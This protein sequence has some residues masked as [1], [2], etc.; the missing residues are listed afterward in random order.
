LGTKRKG[1]SQA[2]CSVQP[3]TSCVSSP[4]P[5][6]LKAGPL[7]GR[8]WWCWDRGETLQA[9]TVLLPTSTV[10]VRQSPHQGPHGLEWL[11]LSH[12][13]ARLHNSGKSEKDKGGHQMDLRTVSL[14]LSPFPCTSHWPEFAPMAM[15]SR[16]GCWEP[17]FLFLTACASR[18]L[19]VSFLWEGRRTGIGGHLA[20]LS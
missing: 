6:T 7:E 1:E 13:R 10:T 18:S 19:G 5:Q 12:A 16:Q 15:L 14:K 11:W 3:S 8:L 17:L 4:M 9:P 2:A 20:V